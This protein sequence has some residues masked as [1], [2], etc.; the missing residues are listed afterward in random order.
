ML[1][2]RLFL[3][4]D[5]LYG[6]FFNDG[7]YISHQA[8]SLRDTHLPSLFLTA[9]LSAFYPI[10]AFYG[11]TL[12]AAAAALA[13]VV[14]DVLI[15]EA[16]VYVLALASAY[17]GW[18]WLARMA[19]VCGWRAHAPAMTY[20]TAPYVITNIYAR[21]DLVETV[22]TAA[23]PL[24]VASAINV[25]RA[26]RLRAG[27]ASALAISTIAF[28]G[29]HNLTLL[30]GTVFLLVLG[31]LIVM[32]I[33]ATRHLIDRSGAMRIAAVAAPAILFNG[34]FLLPDLY[35]AHQTVIAQRANDART[36]LRSE[37]PELSLGHLFTP[38]RPDSANAAGYTLPVLVIAWSLL[39]AAVIRLRAWTPWRRLLVLFA[40]V[41]LAI[42]VLASEAHLIAQLPSPWILLQNGARLMTFAVFGICAMLIAALVLVERQRIQ[43]LSALLIPTLMIS[44]LQALMQIDQVRLVPTPIRATIDGVTTFGLG[45]YA[46]GTLP[47]LLP[48]ANA[49]SGTFKHGDLKRG[50]V[51]ITLPSVRE[52]KWLTML[53]GPPELL[54]IQGGRIVGRWPD[55]PK[56]PGWQ[57]R[58]YLVLQVDHGASGGQHKVVISPGRPFPVVAGRVISV[59]GLL[60]LLALAAIIALRRVRPRPRAPRPPRPPATA[61]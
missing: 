35:Y 28:T 3:D 54:N 4:G 40:G 60:G 7:W 56:K 55:A 9:D 42:A 10:F 41:V 12:F 26:H 21:Q 52:G 59:L 45:D 51:E 53:M 6:D 15:A 22:A 11:G 50:R 44:A 30:Y 13:L 18:Y 20:V 43:W 49:P 16:I 5:R 17:G 48:P 32:T 33:P 1:T 57:T 2:R 36:M 14:G 23:M 31:L 27:P 37:P 39:A 29:S 25:G 38:G 34:W 58:W 19:G 47:I 61:L 8:A 46:D 24:M